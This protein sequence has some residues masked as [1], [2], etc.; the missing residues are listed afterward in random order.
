MGLDAQEHREARKH[1]MKTCE[2]YLNQEQIREL[3]KGLIVA[4]ANRPIK[5]KKGKPGGKF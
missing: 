4:I 1:V 3:K 2:M 5:P